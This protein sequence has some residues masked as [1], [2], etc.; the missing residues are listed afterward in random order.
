VHG[1]GLLPNT[2]M[3]AVV[4]LR[5][6]GVYEP[7]RPGQRNQRILVQRNAREPHLTTL[8]EIGHLL[9]Q[10]AL[11]RGGGYASEAPDSH[12]LAAWRQAVDTTPTVQR[13]QVAARRGEVTVDLNGKP[14]RRGVNAALARRLLEAPEL[15]ARSYAQYIAQHHPGHSVYQELERD[16]ATSNTFSNPISEHWEV[17]EFEPVAKAFDDLFT[18]RL[19]SR[20][21]ETE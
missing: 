12:A 4:G 10:H 5:H 9:D 18:R 2:T 6:A 8:H 17:V 13:L 16:L 11:G 1:D 14:V 20:A 19:W 7:T 21:P 3:Q 15:F